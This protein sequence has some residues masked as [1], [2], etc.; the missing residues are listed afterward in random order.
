MEE[1][2]YIVQEESPESTGGS[3]NRPFLTAVGIL[4]VIFILAAGCSAFSLFSRGGATNGVAAATV[5]AIETQNAIV[6][7]TNEAVTQTI[8]AME[9]EAARPTETPAPPTATSTPPPTE[10]PQPTETPVVAGGEDGAETGS[11]GAD[12][13]AGATDGESGTTTDPTDDSTP[14]PIPIGSGGDNGSLP[15]TGFDVWSLALIALAL[16]AV[17]LLARRFRP[18]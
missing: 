14:T 17:A 7:V 5:A 1:E 12:G 16:A 9:T 18:A 11:D 8:I 13:D 6:A 2:G 3:S 10:T 15:D 4:L